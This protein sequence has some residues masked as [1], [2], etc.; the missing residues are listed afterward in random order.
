LQFG[1]FN[2]FQANIVIM[3]LPVKATI[4]RNE[5]LKNEIF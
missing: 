2:F 1:S 5:K 3:H 4:K